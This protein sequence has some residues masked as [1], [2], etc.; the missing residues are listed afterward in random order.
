MG[1]EPEK[2][3]DG[4][5]EVME[6]YYTSEDAVS[7]FIRADRMTFKAEFGDSFYYDCV[8]YSSE[9]VEVDGTTIPKWMINSS[10]FCDREI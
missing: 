6:R 9:W 10:V 7:A 3:D 1:L 4:C 2:C 5:L 8:R